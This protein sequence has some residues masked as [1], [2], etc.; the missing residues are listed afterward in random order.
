MTVSSLFGN[1]KI[2]HSWSF[3]I[4][5]I[6]VII[7]A[8]MGFK[9]LY[10]VPSSSRNLFR[11]GIVQQLGLIWFAFRFHPWGISIPGARIID[12]AMT[13]AIVSSTLFYLSQALWRDDIDTSIKAGLLCGIAGIAF[14]SGYP[15][16]LSIGGN[17]WLQGVVTMYP[18]QLIGFSG[19]VYVPTTWM[20]ATLF[21]GASLCQR[22]I[23]TFREFG[24]VFRVGVLSVLLMTVLC[25]EVHIPGVSTQRLFIPYP[26]PESGSI[27]HVVANILDTSQL[28]QKVL[29]I[30]R[31]VHTN[32]NRSVMNLKKYFKFCLKSGCGKAR[33]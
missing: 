2:L 21:F 29:L 25:Q 9:L 10:K 23:I 16:H 27:A 4:Y 5:F 15:I 18:K 6:A 8:I 20:Y 14:L 13:C 19:Y 7:N 22:N 32:S 1:F 17:E 31:I 28:A 30:I 12:I 26:I 24:M 3:Y 11:C 33:K